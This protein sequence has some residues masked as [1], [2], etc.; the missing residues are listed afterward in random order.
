MGSTAADNQPQVQIKVMQGEREMANDNKILGQFDLVGIPPAPRGV[1]Q[2]EVA[3]DIDADG[4]L[5]VVERIRVLVNHNL[6]SFKVLVAYRK[7]ISKK[8]SKTPKQMQK[9]IPNVV[10]LSTRRMKSIV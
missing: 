8:W 5:N 10:K 7:T 4:L 2:I 3:F 1:P 6:S 9:L